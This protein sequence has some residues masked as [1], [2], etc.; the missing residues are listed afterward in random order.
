MPKLL[1]AYDNH[2]QTILHDFLESCADTTKQIC[3]DNGVDF[4]TICPPMLNEKNTI[5]HMQSHSVCVVAAHGDNNFTYINSVGNKIE[6]PIFICVEFKQFGYEIA[7]YTV[8]YQYRRVPIFCEEYTYTT[9]DT[10][11]V[12]SSKGVTNSIGKHITAFLRNASKI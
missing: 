7:V 6:C 5:D 10:M 2:A 1:I 8:H 12:D 3:Y 9:K 11:G 4:S